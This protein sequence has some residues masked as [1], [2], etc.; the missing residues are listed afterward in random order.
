MFHHS[1]CHSVVLA[2]VIC[3]TSLLCHKSKILTNSKTTPGLG[4]G[5]IEVFNF[6][7]CFNPLEHWVKQDHYRGA[8]F[9]AHKIKAQVFYVRRYQPSLLFA[10]YHT[11]RYGTI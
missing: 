3:P 10:S 6:V 2:R 9:R 1:Y 4:Y 5:K 7:V 11:L 8:P